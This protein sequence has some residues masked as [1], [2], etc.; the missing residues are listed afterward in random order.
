MKHKIYD[1]EIKLR[2]AIQE[3]YA[4]IKKYKYVQINNQVEHALINLLKEM[5]KGIPK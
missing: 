2:Q 4:D 1:I 5:E 3:W